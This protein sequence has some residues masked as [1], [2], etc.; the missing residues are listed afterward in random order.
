MSDFVGNGG[1]NRLTGMSAHPDGTDHV[2]AASAVGSPFVAFPEK[3]DHF[4]FIGPAFA[5]DDKL[6]PV[7][8]D[9]VVDFGLGQQIVHIYSFAA[10][11]D[12]VAAQSG[13]PKAD[14]VFGFPASF[15]AVFA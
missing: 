7:F 11:I 5:R 14:K 12:G 13:F 8:V 1:P 15:P 6:H 9:I 2:A 4:V 3:D 10:G